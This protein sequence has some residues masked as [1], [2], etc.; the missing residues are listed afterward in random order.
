MRRSKKKRALAIIILLLACLLII[1]GIALFLYFEDKREQNSDGNQSQANYNDIYYNGK[2][3]EYNQNIKN[4]LFLGIDNEEEIS[5]HSAPGTG[6]QAD[7][8]L[9]LSIDK[10]TK[11]AHILQISRDSMTEVD[12]YD[13]QGNYYTSVEAQLA[14]QYAYGNGADTS[15]WAMK[16][17]VGELLFDLPISGYLALDIA[18][19]PVVNDLLGGVTITIPEDYTEIDTAFVKGETVTLNGEQAE[20]YVRYRDI[21]MTGANNLR[22]QRQVQYISALFDAFKGIAGDEEETLEKFYSAV[23]SYAVTDITADELKEMM[24]YSWDAGQ[25]DYVEG[26]AVPGEV[27][28]E[29]YIDEEKLEKKLIEIFYKLK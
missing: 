28:E 14:T 25:V 19:V 1:I 9:L 20:R 12:L 11:E 6:G 23:S 16:K 21:N 15:C 2:N 4:Y 13:A 18:A 3:Y 29:F 22:M 10:E 27:S 26:E 17:T 7:C 5:Q 8:I 24:K